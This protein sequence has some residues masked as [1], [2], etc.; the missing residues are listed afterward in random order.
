MSSTETIEKDEDTAYDE[1]ISDLKSLT[2]KYVKN[3]KAKEI[4]LTKL[5][6]LLR[7]IELTENEEED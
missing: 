2:D 5:N 6:Q 7:L 4:F 3:P 1:V